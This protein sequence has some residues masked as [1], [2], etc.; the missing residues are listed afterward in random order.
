MASHNLVFEDGSMQCFYSRT[1]R[2]DIPFVY[3]LM[4]KLFISGMH[5]HCVLYGVVKGLNELPAYMLI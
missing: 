2:G 1:G 4:W 3:R 5:F